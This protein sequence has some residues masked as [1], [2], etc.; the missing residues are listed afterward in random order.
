MILLALLLQLADSLTPKPAPPRA[1]WRTLIG[2]YADGPE[3]LYVYED[4]GGLVMLVDSM[5]PALLAQRSESVFSSP[6]EGPL[7]GDAL[8][9]FSPALT[10]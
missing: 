7:G 1:A 5:V 6:A 9:R 4:R 2:A 3:T 10:K 8:V